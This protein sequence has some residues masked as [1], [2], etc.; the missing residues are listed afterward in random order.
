MNCSAF[1]IIKDENKAELATNILYCESTK[2]QV[3]LENDALTGWPSIYLDRNILE[4]SGRQCAW[5]EINESGAWMHALPPPN[6]NSFLEYNSL[7]ATVALQLGC[8]VGEPHLCICGSTV[9]ANS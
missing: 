5:D 2:L 3:T 1:I 7:R 8:N 4:P 6:Y 9:E